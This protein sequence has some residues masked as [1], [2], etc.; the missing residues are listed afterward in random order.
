MPIDMEKVKDALRI[1]TGAGAEVRFKRD[2]ETYA[3]AHG[4]STEE[5]RKAVLAD[6]I[7]AVEQEMVLTG[8]VDRKS[9]AARELQG[10]LYQVFGGQTVGRFRRDANN[11]ALMRPL[12]LAHPTHIEIGTWRSHLRGRNGGRHPWNEL[13]I[14]TAAA[15]EMSRMRELLDRFSSDPRLAGAG[16][17][18]V[19]V[20]AHPELGADI[21]GMLE[22]KDMLERHETRFGKL[23][24]YEAA[25]EK[26]KT[27]AGR[28]IN[29]I[30]VRAP[31]EWARDAVAQGVF[32]RQWG[33]A[34]GATLK[35]IYRETYQV[36]NLTTRT[37]L[38]V[39]NFLRNKV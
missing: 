36:L 33:K 32:R 21:G 16:D 6:R 13:D 1:M 17:L 18:R 39:D 8:V 27:E 20:A 38:Q 30:F 29:E 4:V 26:Y 22:A 23:I 14:S 10:S 11:D 9:R 37:I 25:T 7:T 28:S 31:F 3:A 2:V 12:A 19:I 5:S 35:L 24:R 15:A 34:L